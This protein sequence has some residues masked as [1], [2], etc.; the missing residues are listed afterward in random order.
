MSVPFISLGVLVF[1]GAFLV[2]YLL[3]PLVERLAPA[4]GMMDIPD[5]RRVHGRPTPRTGGMAVFVGFHAGC[6]ASVLFPGPSFAGDLDV[7]WW[8]RFLV[9]SAA[10][11][12]LGLA[13]DAL[14]LRPVVKLGGQTAVAMLAY[15]LDIRFGT[16]LGVPLPALVDLTLTLVW[17]LVFVNIFNLIDGMDGV[18]TGLALVAS[19]GIVLSLVFRGKTGDIL[20]LLA[21]AGAC[22]AFLRY[23][24]HPARIFLGDCGSMF[25]GLT[26]AAVALSTVSKSAVLPSLLVPF[27][28]AGV[29]LF[30][31][32]LAVWRRGVRQRGR[33][34]AIFEGDTDHLHHRLGRKGMSQR[35]VAV[36]LYLFSAALILV[37]LLLM[38][39]H[40]FVVGISLS[41]F[42]AGVY[43]IVRHLARVELWDT[44]AALLRGLQRPPRKALAVVLYPL[45]DVLIMAGALAVTLR[46]FAGPIHGPFAQRLPMLSVIWVG[47][48]FIVLVF[49]GTYRRVWSRAGASEFAMLLI[50][51]AGGLLLAGGL[52]NLLLGFSGGDLIAC[53]LPYGGLTLAAVIGIRC[54]RPVVL[55]LMAYG[56]PRPAGGPSPRRLL[57]YG[58]ADRAMLFLSERRYAAVENPG[59]EQIVGLLDDD[60]NLHGRLIHGYRV[61]GGP[62]YLL[63]NTGAL[64]PDEIVIAKEMTPEQKALLL[65]AATRQGIEVSEWRTERCRV[66]EPPQGVRPPGR[67][68]GDETAVR[69]RRRG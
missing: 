66:S 22:L 21:F 48:P 19:L 26:L 39:L 46:F 3:T 23:N 28:A 50:A 11:L 16:A 32:L 37:G 40:S 43:V 5:S 9:V 15:A 24:F 47:I 30:D 52:A 8:L 1:G 12:G 56:W 61:L 33:V 35:Q 58:A 69:G 2:V 18:A 34:S 64:A 68:A 65:D 38:T 55:D 67:R 31:A 54:V 36:L 14:P 20:P 6:A 44:G 59:H 45:V 42:V 51:L 29:P 41:A 4:L 7:S 57:L 27:M 25:L 17:F 53:L 63:E 49:A 62:D 10:L 60:S 13:D